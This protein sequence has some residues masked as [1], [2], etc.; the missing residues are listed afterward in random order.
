MFAGELKLKI[1]PNRPVVK[2]K[3]GVEVNLSQSLLDLVDE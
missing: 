3:V 1:S 2:T